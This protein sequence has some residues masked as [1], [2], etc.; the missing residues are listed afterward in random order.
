MKWFAPTLALM[1]VSTACAF[2]APVTLTFTGLQNL[3]PIENYYNGGSGGFGSSG[4]PNYGISFLSDSLAVIS[5]ANGGTGNLDKVPA[6][7]TDTAAFFLS[8]IGDTLNASKGFTTG[9]AFYYSAPYYTGSVQVYSG[10]N[11][12]GTLLAT[13]TLGLTNGYCDGSP[14]AYSC[15]VNSGVSFSG[16]AESAVFSGT[17]NYVA[18]ADITTGSNYVPNPTVTPEPSTLVLGGTGLLGLAG[19]VRRR[20]LA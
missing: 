4:G 1:A 16:T 5:A 19:A 15:W 13:D 17:A 12:T 14:Y 20:F 11:G 3:E 6:P 7:G 10:L 18:F 9:F 8:G 2:A